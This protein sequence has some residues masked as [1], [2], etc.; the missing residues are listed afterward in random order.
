LSSP[1]SM[2]SSQPRYDS[3]LLYNALNLKYM[4]SISLHRPM[5][6]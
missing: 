2:P 6:N 1:S 4:Y 3:S 5:L